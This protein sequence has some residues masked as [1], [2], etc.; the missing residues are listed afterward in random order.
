[1]SETA[2][3]NQ[4]VKTENAGDK[5]YEDY[6]LARR[7][8]V[9]IVTERGVSRDHQ[10]ATALYLG[11]F[12]GLAIPLLAVIFGNSFVKSLVSTTAGV[13]TGAAGVQDAISL[14]IGIGVVVF[15]IYSA[16]FVAIL[17]NLVLSARRQAAWGLMILL[18]GPAIVLSTVF[19]LSNYIK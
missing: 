5:E 6:L 4:P 19:V 8:A 9:R 15:T 1:M 18:T 7:G 3:E 2:P 17:H 16:V 13:A 12:F 11:L 10:A 14:A